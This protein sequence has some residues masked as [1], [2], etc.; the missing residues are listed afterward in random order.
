MIMFFDF[1]HKKAPKSVDF[2]AD[3]I[4]G[5][6]ADLLSSIIPDVIVEFVH[7]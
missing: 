1:I 5:L 3:F 2:G 7:V 6:S 4:T